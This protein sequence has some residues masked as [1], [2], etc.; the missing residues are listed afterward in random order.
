MKISYVYFDIHIHSKM[1]IVKLINIPIS[2]YSTFCVCVCMCV[3]WKYLK[4]TLSKYPIFSTLLAIVMFY[5]RSPDSFILH[6]GNFVLFTQY[7]P[8]FSSSGLVTM[9]Y[10]C[11]HVFS[12][13]L[14]SKCKWD[15]A[16]FTYWSSYQQ[17]DIVVRA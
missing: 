16:T 11:F 1:V 6:N 14:D 12:F 8:I 10:S 4:S 2:S 15:H 9:F 7:L 5:T 17:Y 3:W 13:F